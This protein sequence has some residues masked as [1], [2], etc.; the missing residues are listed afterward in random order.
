[1][2]AYRASRFSLPASPPPR[3]LLRRLVSWTCFSADTNDLP[4][5]PG[6]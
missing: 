4:M 3:F 6:A 5:L 2:W 1:M